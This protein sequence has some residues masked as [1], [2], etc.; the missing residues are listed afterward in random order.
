MPLKFKNSQEFLNRLQ[1]SVNILIAIPMMIFIYFFLRIE[2]QSYQPD[3]LDAGVLFYMRIGILL[4]TLIL[5]IFGI[6]AFRRQVE[7][8]NPEILLRDKLEFY[9]AASMTRS[10][11]FEIATLVTLIGLI[12]SAEEVYVAYYTMTLV[13]FSITYP[14]THRIM[15]QLK[16]KKEE[17]EILMARKEI[18]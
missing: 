4:V 10:W 6:V 18:E 7:T 15:R 8:I 16:L 17:R 5:V 14:T 11:I 9:F 1:M 2:N 3:L 13:G 12:T